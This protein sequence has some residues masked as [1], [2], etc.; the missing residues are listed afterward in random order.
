MGKKMKTRVCKQLKKQFYQA[1]FPI[2]R[3]CWAE[4]SDLL[5]LGLLSPASHLP[6]NRKKAVW[7]HD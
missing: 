7:F 1:M 4:S 5:L 6:G 2:G 3:K